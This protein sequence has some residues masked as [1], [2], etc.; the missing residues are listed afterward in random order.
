MGMVGTVRDA[1]LLLFALWRLKVGLGWLRRV[2]AHES[3]FSDL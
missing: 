2:P 3:H 1:R